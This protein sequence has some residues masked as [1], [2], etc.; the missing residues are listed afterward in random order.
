MKLLTLNTHSWLEEQP[1][2]KL[3][4]LI[5]TI[6]ENR[7]DIIALQEVNQSIDAS[8]LDLSGSNDYQSANIT[9][10]IKQDNFAFQLQQKLKQMGL[11]YYWTW[12]PSHIGYDIYDEGLA[13]LSLQPIQ[14]VETFRASKSIAYDNHKTRF[15]VGIQVDN[16][17]Y[18][19]LH[20]GW[21]NDDEDTF[22]EQWAVCRTFFKTLSGSIYLMGD[23]NSP[24]QLSGEGYDLVSK[25]WF[26]TFLLANKRDTGQTVENKI[27][28]WSDNKEKLRLD[29]IF[30]N[31]TIAVKKS[32]VLFN[33]INYPVI[34]DHYGVSIEL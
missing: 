20:L 28:G 14:Q 5:K 7:F 24:S 3:D 18:F 17:W 27:D 34:S 16:R 31:K 4:T 23:F 26:D 6:L 11:R 2:D 29:F 9:V 19:N 30:T 22:K 32:E 15:I 33:G 1:Y 12:Q 10:Q 25:E 8:L 13:F 21:W